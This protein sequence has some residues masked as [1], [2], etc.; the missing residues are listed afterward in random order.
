MWVECHLTQSLCMDW[1]SPH[2]GDF[3]KYLLGILHHWS[4]NT[5]W[6][7]SDLQTLYIFSSGGLNLTSHKVASRK[8]T[9]GEIYESPKWFFTPWHL[10][11]L[12]NCS[13]WPNH[14][15]YA[16][17]Q[18]NTADSWI[19]WFCDSEMSSA[20]LQVM[21]DSLWSHHTFISFKLC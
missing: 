12:G 6:R 2:K 7:H 11:Y 14:K 17:Q 18:E 8:V 21:L 3:T 19:F 1:L 4:P 13:N 20:P 5:K 10:A 15:T 16:F 9:W